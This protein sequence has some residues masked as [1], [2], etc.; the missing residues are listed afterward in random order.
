MSVG[1]NVVSA[2][3]LM[4]RAGQPGLRILDASWF[5]PGDGRDARAGFG[6]ARIP[7][8][9]FFDLDAV[10]RP[11]AALSHTLPDADHFAA[12]AG[13]V[14]AQ[15]QHCIVIYDAA[16]MAPSARAWWM[17]KVFGYP[18]VHVLDGG[19]AGWRAAGGVLEAGTPAAFPHGAAPALRHQPQRVVDY[20][21]V[22]AASRSSQQIVDARPPLRFAGAA[23]E[24]R[25]G[26]PGGHIPGSINLPYAE[27][28]D[29]ADGKLLPPGA[30]RER[31]ESA[32][33]QPEAP[34][35]CTCGSG[36]TA[37]VLALALEELGNPAVRV[38]DG[39]WSDWSQHI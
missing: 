2:P 34:A 24:P 25:A 39:S 8:A 10:A 12:S 22:R 11:D 32:G 35:I 7:G 28:I 19:L 30:L 38:Y 37:C 29:P 15:P 14:D 4:H 5:Q 17:F 16:G 33:I 6:A 31:F 1:G 20:A 21:L 27:L 23:P 26:V 18:Q 36:V 13:R 9:L 3:W